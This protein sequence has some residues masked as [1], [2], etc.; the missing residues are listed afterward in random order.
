MLRTINKRLTFDTLT[1]ALAYVSLLILKD[2]GI[3]VLTVKTKLAVMQLPDL[4]INA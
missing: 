1:Q 2:V 3:N 4:E